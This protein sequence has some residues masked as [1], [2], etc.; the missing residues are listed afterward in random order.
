MT[1]KNSLLADWRRASFTSVLLLGAMCASSVAL[2]AEQQMEEIHTHA[3]RSAESIVGWSFTGEPIKKVT[4][5]YHVRYD[6]LDLASSDDIDALRKRVTVAALQA[7]ADLGKRYANLSSN[8]SCSAAA[9]RSARLQV[10][11]AIA[12]VRSGE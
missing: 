3:E 7:C 6:D 1:F 8:L 12:Q 11:R 10:D 2:A 9:R 4:L 5:Q